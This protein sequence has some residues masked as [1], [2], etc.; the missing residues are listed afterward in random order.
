MSNYKTISEKK[1]QLLDDKNNSE[2]VVGE[3]VTVLEGKIS[4][5]KKDSTKNISC[6]ISSLEDGITVYEGYKRDLKS[7][8][9]YHKISKEDITGRD[10][11]NIGTNPFDET[12]YDIRQVSYDL[13]SILFNLDILGGKHEYKDLYSIDEIKIKHLNW[14]PFI[15]TNDGKKQYYQRAFVWSLENKQTLIESIYQNVD[16]GKILIRKRSFDEL[17]TLK[18]KGETDL[19]FND[20]VDGKQRLNTIKL[21]MEGE[22]PDLNGNYYS[23]LSFKAQNNFKKHQLLSYSEMNENTKDEYV[24]KQFLRLNFTGVP[25]SKEH[26]EYVK[27]LTK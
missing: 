7:N 25:Q 6:T 27:S 13:E 24:I 16:L 22:F 8:T 19:A 5:Y 21:F 2:L 23:D 9:R 11:L 26:I 12:S 4:T 20:I 1:Q 18:E 15:Y 3:V 14:N 10:L 17:R